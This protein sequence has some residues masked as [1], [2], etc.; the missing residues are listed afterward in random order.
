MRNVPDD[1]WYLGP[2]LP[3]APHQGVRLG[4]SGKLTVSRFT[5]S[6]G[7]YLDSEAVGVGAVRI[8]E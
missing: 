2:V 3:H 1:D 5:V 4:L 6:S 7:G 8:F